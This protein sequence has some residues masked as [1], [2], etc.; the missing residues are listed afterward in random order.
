M[1]N[2]ELLLRRAKESVSV[3]LNKC[4]PLWTPQS[5]WPSGK[6]LADMIR[7]IIEALWEQKEEDRIKRAVRDAASKKKKP[8]DSTVAKKDMPEDWTFP[9]AL[10]FE[11]FGMPEGEDNCLAVLKSTLVSSGPTPRAVDPNSI[12]KAARHAMGLGEQNTAAAKR[13]ERDAREEQMLLSTG[14]ALANNNLLAAHSAERTRLSDIVK[15][16]RDADPNSDEYRQALENFRTFLKTPCKQLT[17]AEF[18][19]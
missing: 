16:E 2:D 1:K 11:K 15:L 3:I 5:E 18:C 7:K 17:E 8:A 14:L 9:E 10:L 13:A 6:K 19:P 12:S 4:N